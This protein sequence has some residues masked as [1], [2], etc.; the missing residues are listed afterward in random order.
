MKKFVF[1]VA[2][3]L[4]IATANAAPK[5]VLVVAQ[6]TDAHLRS[7]FDAPARFRAALRHLRKNY[8]EVSMVINTGDSVDG[9]KNHDDAVA[10]WGFWKAGIEGE[11]RGIPVYSVLGNHDIEGPANDPLCGKDGACRQFNMPSRYYS[12]DRDG[13]HF[14]MLD[15]NGFGGDKEQMAWLEKELNTK[16]P[17]AVVSHQPIFSVGAALH[18]PGDF[19][20]NWKGLMA[21]FVKYPNVKLSLSGHVHLF[22]K[23]WYNGVS[24][25]C[26]G[27][28]SGYWWELKNSHDG[29]GAYHETRPGYG[30]AKLYADG[31]SEYEY[32]KFEN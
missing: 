15:G 32:V 2:T 31:S 20:G 1:A 22:D 23:A 11:L 25:V 8:P 19:I 5:P 27:A 24:Y 10:K 26:G 28:L 18:Y 6:I 4:F 7:E 21:L 9:V 29:K 3:C 12:F 30:I 13:W 17:V 16:A 14:V